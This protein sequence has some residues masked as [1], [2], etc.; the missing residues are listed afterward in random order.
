MKKAIYFFSFIFLL[1]A[2]SSG[3]PEEV[4]NYDKMNSADSQDVS[5]V[6]AK[7]KAEGD[8]FLAKNRQNLKSKKTFLSICLYNKSIIMNVFCVC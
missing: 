1:S 3:E 6:Y 8:A 2:C 4:Q 7:E 5:K